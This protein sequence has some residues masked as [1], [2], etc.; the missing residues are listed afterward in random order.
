MADLKD[1]VAAG[2][3]ECAC[4]HKQIL[5]ELRAIK[6]ILTVA[7]PTKTT[8]P[9]DAAATPADAKPATKKTDQKPKVK[10]TWFKEHYQQDEEFR[11]RM[12]TTLPEITTLFDNNKTIKQKVDLT[13]KITAQGNFLM[14]TGAKNNVSISN[15]I[16][17]EYKIYT[18]N[19]G[20]VDVVEEQP[21]AR[22]V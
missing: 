16:D 13:E 3:T 11:K 22:T 5:E 7:K 10:S 17:A 21:P 4:D 12:V 19:F 8:K 15:F 20:K 18:D 1:V 6:E 2:F 9:A 14:N